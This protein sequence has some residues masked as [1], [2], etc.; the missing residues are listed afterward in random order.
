MKIPYYLKEIRHAVEVAIAAIHGEQSRVDDLRKELG[1]L[2]EATA[3]GYRRAE[4]LAMN[5]ELDDEGL[6]TAI[7]W[8]TYFGS[9]KDRYHKKAEAD[10]AIQ[11]VAAHEFAVDAMCG[12]LLQYAKQ[13]VALH[14]GK[15]RKGCPDGRL[16][17]GLTLHE[18]V[19]QA[20][21]Q[22]LHWEDGAFHKATT[23]CFEHL[24]KHLDPVF[25]QYQTRSMA[26]E[27]VLHLGWKA[28]DDF[29]RDMMLL[30]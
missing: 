20:R 30:A 19:W 12:S 13:G 22:A 4:F 15:E 9:D 6:G 28:A 21:N 1:A 23:A 18:V 25:N 8:D 14:F 17:A 2:T 27:I 16:I 29:C 10:E 26:H 5:P 3:D 24:A 7:H 11:R